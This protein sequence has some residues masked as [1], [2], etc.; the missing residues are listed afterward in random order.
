MPS[1]LFITLTRTNTSAL[2]LSSKTTLL[3]CSSS[4]M[5]R[6][7]SKASYSIGTV[8]GTSI[9]SS[10]NSPIVSKDCPDSFWALRMPTAC[11][12]SMPF[13]VS[14]KI[15]SSIMGTTSALVTGLKIRL[16]YLTVPLFSCGTFSSSDIESLSLMLMLV[17]E[18]LHLAA[19][20]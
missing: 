17:I 3:V 6:A 20:F 7:T 4:I 8:K 5:Y 14:L 18:V 13:S 15:M 10:F 1:R 16:S 11:L 2:A 9:N 19:Q 12:L